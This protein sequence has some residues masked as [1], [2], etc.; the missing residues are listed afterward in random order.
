MYVEAREKLVGWLR[1]QLIGPAPGASG[2]GLQFSPLDRYP[3]GV[4]HPIDP[5]VSGRDPA[6]E[7]EHSGPDEDDEEPDNENDKAQSTQPARRPRY[8]PPS[9]LGFSFFLQ[10]EPRLRITA[11]AAIYKSVGERD[12]KGRFVHRE[13]DREEL[14]EASIEC[15]ET[16]EAIIWDGRAGIDV[17]M[18][19]HRNGQI[20]TV[21][22]HNRQKLDPNANPNERIRDRTVQSLFESHIECRIESGDL[23]HYP[24]VEPSLLDEEEQ[25]LELQW[26][27]AWKVDDGAGFRMATTKRS[28]RISTGRRSKFW[29]RHNRQGCRFVSTAG[30]PRSSSNGFRNHSAPTSGSAVR[31][32]VPTSA[33]PAHPIPTSRRII[34][35]G[36]SGKSSMWEG[37]RPIPSPY[38]RRWSIRIHRRRE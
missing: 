14:T 1:E 37:P 27:A 26:R 34:L 25:E 31:E 38:F 30:T 36:K 3:T 18:R 19:P 7:S 15:A 11:F 8:V 35:R 10:G 32:R 20:V 2:E 22:L 17:R 21:S 12:E 23:A 5:G 6:G 16:S 13:Y 28:L 33:C 9:S 4:L 29:K 24:R